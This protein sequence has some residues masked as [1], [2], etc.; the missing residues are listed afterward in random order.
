MIFISDVVELKDKDIDFS[1]EGCQ[2]AIADILERLKKLE[3]IWI[4]VH[5]GSMSLRELAGV[6][7]MDF[8]TLYRW[9]SDIIKKKHELRKVY[10][11]CIVKRK[12]LNAHQRFF[13]LLI[14]SLRN[15]E[16]LGY[17]PLSYEEISCFLTV[18][19]S[20]ITLQAFEVWRSQL[21]QKTMV[22]N[23]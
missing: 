10:E 4:V 1:P 23:I 8:S 15:R 19:T 17:R 21:L 5:S 22:E 18:V 11:S 20:R 9:R 16:I 14:W 2:V 6:L 13:Y 12:R 3:V 7:H